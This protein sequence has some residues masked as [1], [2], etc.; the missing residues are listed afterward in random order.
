MG[1]GIGLIYL[2]L[3]LSFKAQAG[4]GMVCPTGYQLFQDGWCRAALTQANLTCPVGYQLF[5]DGWCHLRT[6]NANFICPS[7]YQLRTD[8]WCHLLGSTPQSLNSSPSHNNPTEDSNHLGSRPSAQSVKPKQEIQRPKVTESKFMVQDFGLPVKDQKDTNRCLQFATTSL[9]EHLVNK[10]R[11]C[12]GFT[13]QKLDLDEFNFLN[14]M[15]TTSNFHEFTD[16]PYLFKFNGLAQQHGVSDFEHKVLFSRPWQ[17]PQSP[18]VN[19]GM[20]QE[21]L[22]QMKAALI[23]YNSPILFV[24]KPASV[25]YWHANLCY[26]FDDNK[27]TEWGKGVLI[28]R[29]SAFG[30]VDAEGRRNYYEMPYQ[31]ALQSGKH[32]TVYYLP[33]DDPEQKLAHSGSISQCGPLTNK[34]TNLASLPKSSQNH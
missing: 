6:A 11:A 32:A 8:G 22:D 1:R 7:G 10:R 17:G 5:T 14:G 3:I 27:Q 2:G 19:G 31:L 23:H 29:D 21:E 33:E 20:S 16:Q 28:C 34:T 4:A 25:N 12:R 30:K 24:Y 13:S 26:G 9:F 18:W 15:G